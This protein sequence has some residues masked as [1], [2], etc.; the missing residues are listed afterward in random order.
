MNAPITVGIK[1]YNTLHFEW[2]LINWCNFNCFYCNAADK[3]V[4]QFS[5][6]TSPGKHELVLKRLSLIDTPFEIDLYG[7]EPTLHP[8]FLDILLELSKMPMCKL[9]EVK[10]NLSK[11]T[12]FLEKT[13]IDDKIRI[14]ASYHAQYYNKEFLNKC[15]LFKD[16]NFYCHINLSDN[17]SDWPQ[18]V[19]MIDAFDLHGVRYDLNI[20]L[21]TPGN[22]I[23]YNDEFYKLFQP[24]LDK[25]SDKN[26]YRFEY[27]DGQE[28][29]LTIFDAIK[30]NKISFTN[31]RCK[32]QLYEI[33]LDGSIV[34]SCTRNMAQFKLSKESLDAFVTC[35][36]DHC[37]ADFMLNFYKEKNV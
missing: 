3:M 17:P 1:D 34:N 11:P 24:R 30:E 8:N 31:Y 20:L 35:P 4:D 9:V 29:H 36:R 32:A 18:I 6:S 26:T 15:I 5:K 27:E 13:F 2:F 33:L 12:H 37:H 19:E 23:K 16:K 7:G 28:E 25:I 22:T 10:T 21:S 14:A